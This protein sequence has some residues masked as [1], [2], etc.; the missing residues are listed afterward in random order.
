MASGTSL[1]LPTRIRRLLAIALA[2]VLLAV[3]L[4]LLS[5]ELQP[6]LQRGHLTIAVKDNLRPLGFRDTA[7]Q[8]QGLEIEIA[9]RLA[10]EL[11]GRA[12]AV[13]FKPVLNQ[14]RLAAVL[15][16]HADLAIAHITATSLRSR[17]V[18]FSLPYYTDG[19]ALVTKDPMVRSLT[20]LTHQ[21]IAVLNHSS[22]VEVLRYRLPQAT[23]VA[24]DS[25]DAAQTLLQQGGAIAFAADASVLTG[26]VQDLPA[27]RRLPEILTAEPLCIVIPKG[28]QYNDLRQR[29]NERLAQWQTDGWLRER[30][31]YWGLP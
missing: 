24:V 18:S 5:E 1:R 31:T 14:D 11:L 20:D 2:G 26:W 22:A 15:D 3:P 9:H 4:P 16:G 6:L 10:Q 30:A 8:L 23:L 13:V 12:D 7:G 28:I 27:Y 29:V 17:L 19:T 21:T 25:Y